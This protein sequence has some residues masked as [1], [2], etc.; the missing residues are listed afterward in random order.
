MT[1]IVD[2]SRGYPGAAAIARAGYDGAMRYI[3]FPERVKCTTHTELADYNR[4]GLSMGLVFQDGK[5]DWAGGFDAGVRN[6]MRARLHANSIGFPRQQPIYMAIDQDI[7]T[8]E[9]LRTV[10]AYINGAASELG[11]ARYTG[12]YGE[13]DVCTNI[14]VHGAAKWFWQT[15]AWSGTPVRLFPGRHL[16][17]RA[18]LVRVGGIDC[19]INDVEKAN[20]GQHDAQGDDMTPEEFLAI[21][22]D[23][24]TGGPAVKM[25][26]VLALLYRQNAIALPTDDRPHDSSTDDQYGHVLNV[27]GRLRRVEGKVDQLLD[28]LGDDADLNVLRQAAREG[29][30]KA[31]AED[32]VRVDITVNGNDS[33]P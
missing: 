16:F 27:D 19:D 32:T 33:Q 21:E 25:S 15:R 13:Y 20:W 7:V 31:L 18:G 9:G 4:H 2:Y 6:A 14:A 5:S 24:Q 29:T 22:I 12:V 17:Q 3:G 1:Q 23:N 28:R 11:G 26:D 8:A 30:A 10:I